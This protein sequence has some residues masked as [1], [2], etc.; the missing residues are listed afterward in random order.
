MKKESLVHSKRKFSVFGKKRA[1]KKDSLLKDLS[2]VLEQKRTE[3]GRQ[4]NEAK[5]MRLILEN[6]ENILKEKE[7]KL[8]DREQAFGEKR[9][10]KEHKE[11]VKNID[12]AQEQL[13]KLELDVESGRDIVKQ[14]EKEKAY[15]KNK[16]K[17]LD[18]K[19]EKICFIR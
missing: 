19:E 3:I 11:L 5:K 9:L 4:Q 10:K 15:L 18:K 13:A 7:Q 14:L 2:K 1:P 6:K 12:I 16:D 8:T 17:N